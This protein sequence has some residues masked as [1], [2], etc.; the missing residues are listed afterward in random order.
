MPYNPGVQD[1]S[2]QLLASGMLNAA[3]TRGQMYGDIGQFMS[4][5]G[6]SFLKQE[7]ERQ[8]SAS[9][10]KGFLN[11]P[12]YQQ[13]IAQNPELTA[14][15]GKIQS[16]K[17]KLSDVRGFLGTLSTMQHMR[18]ETLKADQMEAQRQYND[19][20]RQQAIANKSAIDAATAERTRQN[21]ISNQLDKTVKEFYDLERME[22]E[23]TPLTSEQSDKLEGMRDNKLLSSVIQAD[24]AGLG[25][26]R[27]EALRLF[28]NQDAL[29]QKAQNQE[30]LAR[31]REMEIDNRRAKAEADL[32]AKRRQYNAGD[33]DV[34]LIPGTDKEIKV[35]WNGKE[36]I[37]KR[38]KLPIE[39][40]TTD[41]SGNKISASFNPDLLGI[42]GGKIPGKVGPMGGG[43]GGVSGVTGTSGMQ[44][45]QPNPE[46]MEEV[47]APM[48]QFAPGEK[49]AAKTLAIFDN[50][51]QARQALERGE[52]MPGQ[53]VTI[54]GRR[55]MFRPKTK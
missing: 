52:I 9:A 36:F 55:V 14:E 1:I 21:E 23:G 50:E 31:L 17:A 46:N 10:I 45:G 27:I 30:L 40:A 53:T 32:A 2:G 38:T 16:G 33:E 6:S 24:K 22:K 19:A 29:D 35:V 15:M 26:N 48:P 37:D 39:S 44:T 42:Y 20:L 11:D 47:A 54:G 13:Q 4:N 51:Q 34:A 41:L 28:M 43:G 49:P 25:G 12:Y 18:E 5:L 3:Q 8:K 7:E